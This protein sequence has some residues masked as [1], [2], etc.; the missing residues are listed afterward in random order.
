MYEDLICKICLFKFV[1]SVDIYLGLNCKGLMKCKKKVLF[2][3]LGN[4][5]IC[6]INVKYL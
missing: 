2:K 5:G 4:Y 3:V 1:N 6:E